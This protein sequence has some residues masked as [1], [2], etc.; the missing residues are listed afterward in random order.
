M[1]QGKVKGR[2]SDNPAHMTRKQSNDIVVI[3]SLEPKKAN[4]NTFA[5]KSN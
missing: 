1:A 4:T 3:I 2:K 5:L